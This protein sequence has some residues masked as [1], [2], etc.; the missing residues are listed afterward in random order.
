M[1][2]AEFKVAGLF[3]FK[4]RCFFFFFPFFLMLM[5]LTG[6]HLVVD[7]VGMDGIVLGKRMML[8]WTLLSVIGHPGSAWMLRPRLKPPPTY[9]LSTRDYFE[10]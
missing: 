4:R 8:R 1:F 7:V 10:A 5:L 6:V 3:A 9:S 2:L